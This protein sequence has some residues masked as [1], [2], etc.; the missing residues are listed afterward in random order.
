MESV[1]SE[2]SINV[3]SS[4][5]EELSELQAE[6]AAYRIE[7]TVTIRQPIRRQLRDWEMRTHDL[8]R[9]I[10]DHIVKTKKEHEAYDAMFDQIINQIWRVWDRSRYTSLS[11]ARSKQIKLSAIRAVAGLNPYLA[12]HWGR[13]LRKKHDTLDTTMRFRIAYYGTRLRVWFNDTYP[14]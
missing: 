4:F 9:H 12:C 11:K 1:Q 7:T 2:S 8:I 10:V 13:V 5:E 6:V 3:A 14:I